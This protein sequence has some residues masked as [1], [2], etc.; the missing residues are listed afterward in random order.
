MHNKLLIIFYLI[1][2]S[3]LHVMYDLINIHVN[4]CHWISFLK[5]NKEMIQVLINF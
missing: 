1:F 5:I 4:V 2:Q 3:I